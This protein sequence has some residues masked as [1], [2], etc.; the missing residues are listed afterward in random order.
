[1]LITALAHIHIQIAGPW[2]SIAVASLALLFTI[3]SF[4]GST[5]A[6]GSSS[7][8]SLSPSRLVER[9]IR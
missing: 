8:L 3:G 4:G 7:P 1:M 9:Q 5:L 6:K 2:L